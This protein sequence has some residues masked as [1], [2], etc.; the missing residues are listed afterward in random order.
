M[1]AWK[2]LNERPD[3]YI[4]RLLSS[5]F[6]SKVCVVGVSRA[7]AVINPPQSCVTKFVR[8]FWQHEP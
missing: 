2:T 8:F 7:V 6:A 3:T 4:V 5:I 1:L